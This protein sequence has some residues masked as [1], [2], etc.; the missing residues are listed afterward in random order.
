MADQK[1]SVP[2]RQGAGGVSRFDPF[3]SLRSEIDRLFEDFGRGWPSMGGTFPS[4]EAFSALRPSMNVAET[5][6]DIEITAEL[7]GLDEKDVQ[8]NLENDVLTLKGE[9]R[10]EKE[11]NDKS[12]HMME[13]SYGSSRARF[14]SRREST[15]SRSRPLFPMAS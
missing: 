8:V 12:Y 2:V 6:K 9:K 3:G 4:R 11:E 14:S 13:R 15:P 1:S 5:D 10:A 7:P